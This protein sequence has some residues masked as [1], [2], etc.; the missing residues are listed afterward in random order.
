MKTLGLGI[1]GCGNISTTYLRLSPLFKG[2]KVRAVADISM[3]AA[4]ARAAE[5]GVLA[6]SV[7]DLLANKDVDV[8]IN[9]TIPD[10]HF[11]ISKRSLE[12]GKHVYSEKPLTLTI[13]EG[14][15]LRDLAK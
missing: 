6:Q 15:T 5:Y 2:L 11:G 8:V 13:E 3:A 10:A 7:D 9:L 4:E 14:I 12:A 1:I